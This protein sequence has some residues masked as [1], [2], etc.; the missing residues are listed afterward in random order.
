M[1]ILELLLGLV[2]GLFIAIYFYAK[3]K[4]QGF[5]ETVK[6]IFKNINK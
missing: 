6:D 1:S 3:Y 4:H 5:I 2:I